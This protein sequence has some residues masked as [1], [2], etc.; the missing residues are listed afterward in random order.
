MRVLQAL[1]GAETGGAELHFVRLCL[2]LH[3]A[4]LDQHVVM[5]P[6]RRRE[7]ELRA[8]GIA[9]IL[10]RFGGWFD[11]RTRFVLRRELRRFRPDIVL[12]YMNRAS[13]KMPR[14]RHVHIARLGG[15]YNLKYYKR[16]DHLVC[17]TPDIVEHCV[18]GGWDRERVHCIPN[19]VEDN[20]APAADRR[21][22]GTPPA[23]P[24]V[25][26]LGRLHENKGFDTLLRAI[27]ALPGAY[28]W[29][30]GDGPEHDALKA[31]TREL[32]IAD[33]VHLLGWIDDPAPLFAAA[34]VFVVPSRHEPLGSVVLEGWMHRAPMIAAA[35]QGPTWLIKDG[36]D[37]LLVPVDDAAALAA[38]IGRVLDDPGLARALARNGRATYEAGY[39]EAVAVARYLALF[40]QV[41]APKQ[42]KAADGG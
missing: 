36:Q 39:T 38:A 24:L 12:T 10:T 37:G 22:Y 18:K 41:L 33:R 9:P 31:L 20:T 23:A 6:D 1:A 14:G 4:G 40:E 7:D 26:A 17:I 32:G 28:L 25:F 29:L 8:G 3:K 5:R 21:S 16:C 34:D 13:K 42:E 19:F 2:A 30:A 15:Y 35:S 27:A 11:L